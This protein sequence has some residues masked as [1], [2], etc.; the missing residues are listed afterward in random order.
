MAAAR[1]RKEISVAALPLA[2]EEER[3]FPVS[4]VRPAGAPSTGPSVVRVPRGVAVHDVMT[5]SVHTVRPTD[6]VF[7]AV[8]RMIQMGVSGLPV[9]SG[10]KLVGVITQND[11]GRLLAERTHL[12]PLGTVLEIATAR[13]ADDPSGPLGRH[14]LELR[15]LKVR[16]AMT[17][18]PVTIAA[19]ASVG[20]AVDR[21][22][23]EQVKRL[24]VLD[25][26]GRLVGI[27]TRRDLLRTLEEGRRSPR[28]PGD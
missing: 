3:A 5:R 13:A 10:R 24:P 9:V 21:M 1:V 11:V 23:T 22:E 27:V 8:G 16:S 2:E 20:A 7:E 28:P 19:T 18:D 14:A 26:R 17:P 15:G 4:R 12:T 6:T 25:D